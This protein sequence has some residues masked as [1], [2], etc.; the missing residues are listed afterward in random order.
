MVSTDSE[1]VLHFLKVAHSGLRQNYIHHVCRVVA[2]R[3]VK[4]GAGVVG[5][6]WTNTFQVQ[7]YSKAVKPIQHTN[8]SENAFFQMD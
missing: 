1:N 3:Q 7:N 2:N 4:L 6:E 8:E 5:L